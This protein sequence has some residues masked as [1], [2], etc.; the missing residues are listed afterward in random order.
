[1]AK[2][3]LTL[4]DIGDEYLAL[5][6]TKCERAG[7]YRVA[8]LI[9]EHGADT[10]LPDLRVTLANCPRHGSMLDGCGVFYPHLKP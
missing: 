5:A 4:A 1:M 9:E 2:G 8:R 7:R 3:S 6:C 10:T